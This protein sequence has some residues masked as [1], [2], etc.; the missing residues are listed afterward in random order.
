[1]RRVASFRRELSDEATT[2]WRVAPHVA[3][4]LFL[5]PVV[6]ALAVI[7]SR[8]S[9]PLYKLITGE[10]RL[11]EW[12]QFFGYAAALVLAVLLALSLWR[13][14]RRGPALAYAALAAGCLLVAGEE[15][16]WGQRV[17]GYGTP[18]E[19]QEINRQGEA[20]VHNI[21]SVQDVFSLALL[22]IG[23]YGSVGAWLFRWRARRRPNEI[24]RLFVPP[25]FLTSAF[26]VLFGYKLIRYVALPQDRFTI[27]EF[28]EWPEFCLAAALPTFV[29]LNLLHWLRAPKTL[30]LLG[31]GTVQG[32]RARG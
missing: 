11:L 17:F 30:P 2:D 8:A 4:A 12:G 18:E 6:G 24:E 3:E 16:A 21:K 26:L 27:V 25:L 1:M 19:L 9:K 23:L 28:G 14:G 22:F 15:I 7:L 29:L 32:H 20:T 10:D 5:L 31:P 13:A